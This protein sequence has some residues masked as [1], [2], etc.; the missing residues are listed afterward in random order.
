MKKRM[1]IL[2]A[3]VLLA[4][5]VTVWARAETTEVVCREENFA[6][7]IPAGASARYEEGTG[8]VIYTHSEGK[9]PYVFVT[10]R[11]MDMKFKNPVSYLENVVREYL[12]DRYGDKFLGMNSATIWNIGGKEL[13]G[14]RYMY[15]VGDTTVTLLWLLEIRDGG[16]V[17]YAAKYTKKTE[18]STIEALG[19]AVQCYRET[20][21]GAPEVPETTGKETAP[22]LDDSEWSDYHCEEE[23]FS[24]KKPYHALTQY[25]D[26]I[27]YVGIAFY[28]DVPG[29]PPYVMVHRRAAEKKFKNPE[30]YLNNTYRE[31]LEDKFASARVS[32]SPAKIWNVG[33][34]QLT[35]AKYTI[36]DEY[37]DTTQL[38]L[39]EVRELGDVEYT[40]MYNSAEEEELV[41]KALE[42]AVANY[43]EDEAKETPAA[44]PA[45]APA[46]NSAGHLPGL[47]EIREKLEAGK[48]I[49]IITYRDSHYNEIFRL[50]DSYMKEDISSLWDAMNTVT[51]GEQAEVSEKDP[52]TYIDIW[53][54]GNDYWFDF[55]GDCFADSDGK[56][57]RLENDSR[58]REVLSAMTDQ[59]MMTFW[60]ENKPI[61]LGKTTPAELAE[62]GWDF[63]FEEDGTIGLSLDYRDGGAVYVTTE[64]A[65]MNRPIMKINAMW[66]DDYNIEYCGFDGAINPGLVEDADPDQRWNREYPYEVLIN[67][68]E[69]DDI[70]VD[71]WGA[72]CNWLV[73]ECGAKVSEEGIYEVEVTLSD[74]R[75]LYIQ[76]HDSAPCVSLI[77]Y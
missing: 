21:T 56:C 46:G 59:A 43:A 18:K 42:A 30:G 36:S 39:I 2:L 45:A 63:S 29:Y 76:S 16:D 17:E 23:R 31:F 20:D 62:D 11:S 49:G 51:V 24:T 5:C 47:E 14:T 22:V 35:G 33:G 60:L 26:A 61:I 74:G 52:R 64:H 37:G 44:S 32:T 58:L 1:S 53:V 38:Q 77:G 4:S 55:A 12:E 73:D 19:T 50:D 40:A 69:N 10:R 27:G 65:S 67:A 57:Y 7:R 8:L 41:M 48:E 71:P 54:N 28:L 6:T 68:W 3:L 9:I 25:K 34:K 75:I 72:M 15:L 13:L 66:A 70:W